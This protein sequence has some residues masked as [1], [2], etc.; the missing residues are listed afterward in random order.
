MLEVSTPTSNP[1]FEELRSN[2]PGFSGEFVGL[3][4]RIVSREICIFLPKSPF[5]KVEGD[6]SFS[7]PAEAVWDYLRGELSV[8]VRSAGSV[9]PFPTR[10]S[11][12]G[13][14][15]EVIMGDAAVSDWLRKSTVR[16]VQEEDFDKMVRWRQIHGLGKVN[17][18]FGT[19]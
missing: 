6:D 17:V 10:I 12:L 15:I 5:I 8:T 13:G 19:P 3:D 16:A 11:E 4:R 2:L 18:N 7:L 1:Y 14:R 9:W